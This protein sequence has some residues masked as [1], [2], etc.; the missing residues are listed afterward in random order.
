M[1]HDIK[2][3][4]AGEAGAAGGALVWK[5]ER[6]ERG[7]RCNKGDEATNQLLVVREMWYRIIAWRPASAEDL[8]MFCMTCTL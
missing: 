2:D 6:M 7:E 1:L 4:L 8:I 5:E 3:C